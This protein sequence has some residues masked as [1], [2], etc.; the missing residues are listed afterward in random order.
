MC[1]FLLPS[2]DL[3]SIAINKCHSGGKYF[4]AVTSGISTEIWQAKKSTNSSE[5]SLFEKKNKKYCRL[6]YC[7]RFC[8]NHI[9]MATKH[10]VDQCYRKNTIHF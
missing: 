7:I 8:T 1:Y 4:S 2:T 5:I 9:S 10:L 6:K 3:V